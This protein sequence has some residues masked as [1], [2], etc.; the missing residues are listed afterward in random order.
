[1]LQEVDAEAVRE[2]IT[3]HSKVVIY[4]PLSDVYLEFSRIFYPER[5]SG[6]R[7]EG[8]FCELVLFVFFRAAFRDLGTARTQ[9]SQ[10]AVRMTCAFGPFRRHFFASR[11]LMPF[12]KAGSETCFL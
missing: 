7:A 8:I 11:N 2:Q 12:C 3:N 5:R 6:I 9:K 10:G 1:M 4:E